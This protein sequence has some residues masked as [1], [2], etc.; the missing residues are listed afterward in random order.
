MQMLPNMMGAAPG[1]GQTASTMHTSQGVVKAWNEELGFGFL[2]LTTNGRSIFFHANDCQG[3][4]PVV[5]DVLS[6]QIEEGS[7]DGQAR[8]RNVTGGSG[9]SAGLM[10]GGAMMLQSAYGPMAA[11]AAGMASG[12]YAQQQ[13]LGQSMGGRVQGQ[14]HSWI[15]GRG[16]GFASIPG[17]RDIFVHTHHCADGF[18]PKKGDLLEFEMHQGQK[19]DGTRNFE[20]H[21]VIL[22]TESA[23]AAGMAVGGPSACCGGTGGRSSGGASGGTTAKLMNLKR[24]SN[25]HLFGC[26]C[27]NCELLGVGTT[28][29]GAAGSGK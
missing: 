19:K 15:E 28:P 2:M 3:C 14:V 16:W 26:V 9:S 4:S 21:Q 13:P 17:C 25:G 8:A 29:V 12:P 6:F 22:V 18:V 1:L 20:A 23:S 10:G 7:E 11:M 27:A 24:N 5:G